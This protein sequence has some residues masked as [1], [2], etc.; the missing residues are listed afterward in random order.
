MVDTLESWDDFFGEFYLRAYA[1]E[2]ADA[3]A[4]T[5]ALAAARLAGCPD[6]GDLLDVPCGYGRHVL[7][8][9]GRGI[10]RRGSTA[11]RCCWPRRAGGPATSAGRS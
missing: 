5:Q 4:E 2:E 3:I 1:S 9:P 7:R 6:G 10:A 11:R 8:S